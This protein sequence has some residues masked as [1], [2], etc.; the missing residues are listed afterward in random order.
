MTLYGCWYVIADCDLTPDL[1]SIATPPLLALHI[2]SCSPPAEWEGEG[3]GEVSRKQ[4]LF[5]KYGGGG[6]K[7]TKVKIMEQIINSCMC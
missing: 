6:A 1:I 4:C 3:K 2:F 5:Q 7:L